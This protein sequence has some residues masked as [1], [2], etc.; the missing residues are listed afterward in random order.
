MRAST[1]VPRLFLRD[2]RDATTQLMLCV[3]KCLY[4]AVGTALLRSMARQVCVCMCVCVCLCVYVCVCVC[5]C[6]CV[7]VCVCMCVYVCVCVC[8]CMYTYICICMCVCVCLRVRVLCI[9]MPVHTILVNISH[10][11]IPPLQT[12]FSPITRADCHPHG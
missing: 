5:V 4:R 6:M 12:F 8:M 3:Q 10:K 9:Y 11:I 7:C 2:A 1:H